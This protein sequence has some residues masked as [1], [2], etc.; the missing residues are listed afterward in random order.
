MSKKP[1]WCRRLSHILSKLC[2]KIS[3]GRRDL[4]E[5]EHAWTFAKVALSA[6]QETG[7]DYWKLTIPMPWR[8]KTEESQ[9]HRIPQIG[10]DPQRSSSP[11]SNFIHWEGDEVLEQV[12][13][14][15]CGC[16]IPGDVQ[17]Q[18]GWGS[19][20]PDAVLDLVVGNPAWG[21]EVGTWWSLRSLPT[22]VIWWVYNSVNSWLH[23]GDQRSDQM[24]EST[25]Q[26]VQCHD[27][28][29][30]EPIPVT[31]H[32]LVKNLFLTLTWTSPVAAPCCSLES[33]HW[34]AER[35]DQCLSLCFPVK[36][37][38][39]AMRSVLS[40]LFPRLNNPRGCN[41]SSYIQKDRKLGSLW[42]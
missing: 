14:R 21:R 11:E 2:Q 8:E 16:S 1:L 10:M 3:Q 38:Q 27:H 13:Q 34:T 24:S 19:G 33:Y 9:N 31:N 40:F 6:I 18:V 7:A 12:A 35:E 26:Q 41:Q 4:V 20:Q 30:E 25:V 32:P 42:N 36:K 5:I 23:T 37:P 39:A 29:L 22:Q 28:C 17:G 15:H